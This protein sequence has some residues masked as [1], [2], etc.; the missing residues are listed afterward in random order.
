[1]LGLL[2]QLTTPSEAQALT[3]FLAMLGWYLLSSAV[4]FMAYADITRRLLG[5]PVHFDQP[6][7]RC[8]YIYWLFKKAVTVMAV[9]FMTLFTGAL[10]LVAFALVMGF[11]LRMIGV[12]VTADPPIW[13]SIIIMVAGLSIS[14]FL[15]THF[16]LMCFPIAVDKND[17][18][19]DSLFR[20]FKVIKP[21]RHYGH[22]MAMILFMIAVFPNMIIG[23]LTTFF[24]ITPEM[25]LLTF[26]LPALIAT[27]ISD[28]IVLFL[29]CLQ[30]AVYRQLKAEKEA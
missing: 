9:L 16:I 10:I 2:P 11:V 26:V 23:S 28:F 7:A 8:T 30:L 21:Y 12:P 18:P 22:Q 24:S 14:L 25:P 3:P 27:S 6:Q 4:L 29:L 17:G 5:F 1:M 19:I 20:G 15:I 13:L